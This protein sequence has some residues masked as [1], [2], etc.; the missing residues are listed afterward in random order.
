MSFWTENYSDIGSINNPKRNFRFKVTFTQFD[1]L[2]DYG[3][4]DLFY[5]KTADKPSF[6]LGETKHSFLNHDFKFPGRVSWNDVSIA[7]VD[8]GPKSGDAETSTTGVASALT[9]LLSVSGYNIPD[10]PSSDY[11]TISKTKAVSGIGD[12]IVTQL[13]HDGSA[14]EEWTLHNAFLSEINYGTLD[15]SSD[16]LTEYKI[17]LRYDW[18]T[19][20]GISFMQSES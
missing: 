5:A 18:A 3:S 8:P 9:R 2:T 20:T 19:Y 15:Y 17:T 10:G 1:D 7:M 13:D 12:V 16:D 11:M 4:S 14:I 6:T